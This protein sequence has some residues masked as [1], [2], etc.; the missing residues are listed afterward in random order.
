[1]KDV[2]PSANKN[3]IFKLL[4]EFV[5]MFTYLFG[6][7]SRPQFETSRHD[8]LFILPIPCG[9]LLITLHDVFSS[10]MAVHDSILKYQ[11]DSS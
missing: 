4:R 6:S 2:H 10:V 11:K 8:R 1:M 5:V 9:N 7:S 3:A